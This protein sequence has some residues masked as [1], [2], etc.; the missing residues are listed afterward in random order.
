M[1]A[2]R[3]WLFLFLCNMMWAL[4]F[5]SVKLIQDQVGFF[6]TV[7]GP[8]T[9]AT[10][11]LYPSVR[12][13]LRSK[14]RPW[15]HPK[16]LLVFLLLAAAGVFPGQFLVT[17][18][19]RLSL[20]SN[21]AMLTLA[22]P[23]CTAFMAYLFLSERMTRIRWIAFALALG[24]VLLCSGVDYGTL[25]FGTAYLFGNLLIFA[26]VNGSAFYNSYGKK[27]LKRFSPLEMLFYTYVAMFLIMTPLTLATESGIFAR[28]PQFTAGTWV[29]LFLLTVFHN[30]LSMILFLKALDY[31]DAIQTALSNYLIAFFGVPIS[32]IW[33]GERMTP[34]MIAGGALVLL[35][36]LLITVWEERKRRWE[37]APRVTSGC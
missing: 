4:Q 8:M 33:L 2:G 37:R 18:G 28:I 21:A 6:F 31:L 23:I 32:A 30:Y 29:G 35:S 10:V 11:F 19:T 3:S 14:G 5:T 24:G 25:N 15:P 27:V 26:G 34:L 9:L 16:E 17:W 22:L 7:W 20:A 13:E 1:S 36:T 12:R